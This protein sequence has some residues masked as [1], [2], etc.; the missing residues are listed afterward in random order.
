MVSNFAK[1]LY[2]GAI[3]SKG[4]RCVLIWHHSTVV[5]F[6]TARPAKYF[7]ILCNNEMA[8]LQNPWPVIASASTR[9][10]RVFNGSVS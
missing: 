9:P 1:S 4:T 8:S 3:S 10:I 7:S 2:R 6:S 5:S